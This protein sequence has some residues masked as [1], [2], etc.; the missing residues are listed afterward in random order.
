MIVSPRQLK[1]INIRPVVE[2]VLAK[3]GDKGIKFEVKGDAA[4]IADEAL[5][6]VLD[7]IVNNAVLHSKSPVL[8]ISID[9]LPEDRAEVRIADEGV[10]IPAEVRPKIW[11]E[12]YKYGS[13]GQS[14]LGLYIVKKVMERYEGSV[15][16]EDNKPQ[17]VAFVLTF[18]SPR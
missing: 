5:S 6:S 14:G 13:A 7:N 18:H 3:Y 1:S 8:R 9:A 12:G 17:G 16:V 2:A 15:A 10:G 4:A 11:Q